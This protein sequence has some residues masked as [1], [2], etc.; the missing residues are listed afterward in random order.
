MRAGKIIGV[1]LLI[2]ALLAGGIAAYLLTLDFNQY[3]PVIAQATK[4]ATGRDLRIDG[5][6]RLALALNPSIVVEGMTL[7]NAEWGTRPHMLSV[8]RF[9][10][11]VGLLDLMSG[12]VQ[13]DRLVLVGPKILLETNSSG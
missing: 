2:L 12:N 8:E 13:V 6:L 5:D 11:Q 4:R 3:K 7:A 10:G 9:E 1:V